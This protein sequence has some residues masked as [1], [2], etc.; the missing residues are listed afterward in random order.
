MEL[1]DAIM[2]RRSV[3]KYTSESVGREVVE[4][5]IDAAIQAPSAMN[6][7]NWA[8]GVIQG[9]DKL[10][11]YSDRTK[12]HLLACEYE[13][14]AGYKEF[15][16][17]PDTNIFYNA[18]CMVVIYAGSSA[19]LADVNCCLAAENLMLS[20]RDMGLGTCWIGFTGLLLNQPDVKKEMGVPDDY[21]AVAPIIIG[22]PSEEMP[23]P[24][25]NA[26]EILF[27]K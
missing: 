12:K 11:E 22:H 6:S 2:S 16:S 15:L 3:R 10:K 26:P 23:Q 20:A 17:N 21:T 19:P 4:K 8:F 24:P 25:R 13:W 18:P 5:L 14:L 27:W 9:A 1:M 7:Q